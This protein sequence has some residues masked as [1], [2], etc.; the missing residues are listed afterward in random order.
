MKTFEELLEE[1]KELHNRKSHD[2]AGEDRLA[3]FRLSR[4]LGIE[5]WIGCLI[6]AGDKYSRLCQFARSKELKV[7][8]ETVEDTLKDLSIYALLAI[9][10]F[11][12]KEGDI[13][14]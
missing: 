4:M 7:K 11:E 9:Q 14:G 2:Y 12:E 1:L 5:P 8:D 13:N 6:R 10:L 3:N